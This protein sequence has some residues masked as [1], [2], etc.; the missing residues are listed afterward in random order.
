MITG[1][2]VGAPLLQMVT[3]YAIGPMLVTPVSG[4]PVL[5]MV[6]VGGM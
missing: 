5:V 1:S 4:L 6:K 3:V 2:L